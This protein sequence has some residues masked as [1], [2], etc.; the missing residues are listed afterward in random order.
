[1]V[2]LTCQV[3]SS[4]SHV[5]AVEWKTCNGSDPSAVCLEMLCSATGGEEFWV[6]NLGVPR[7]ELSLIARFDEEEHVLSPRNDGERVLVWTPFYVN[8]IYA[9]QRERS[10]TLEVKDTS[11]TLDLQGSSKG[12]PTVRDA[13]EALRPSRLTSAVLCAGAET[14]ASKCEITSSTNE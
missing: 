10:V 8:W 12:I 5:Q 9:L 2:L 7:N 3:L 4:A 11:V 13:C 14:G 6:S 1:M